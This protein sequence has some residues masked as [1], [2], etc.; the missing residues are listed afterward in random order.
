MYKKIAVLGIHASGKTTIA[1]KLA[2]LLGLP[3]IS[4]DPIEIVKNFRYRPTIWKT[5]ISS[6]LFPLLCYEMTRR[7]F[8]KYDKFVTDYDLSLQLIYVEIE[9]MR[10]RIM[11]LLEKLPKYDL[12]I[13][14]HIRDPLTV[15][16]RAVERA[17]WGSKVLT[18]WWQAYYYK[19]AVVSIERFNDILNIV[20][21]R[22]QKVIEVDA[23]KELEEIINEIARLIGKD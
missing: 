16:W 15:V 13:I 20:K 18:A 23:E 14:L 17:R 22:G 10:R 11:K 19:K 6:E 7:L 8:E 4:T 21:S 12:V 3:F 2:Q 5:T 1:T 9:E